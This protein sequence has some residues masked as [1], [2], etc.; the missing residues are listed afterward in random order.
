MFDWITHVL[1]Q[2]G[3]I[4][5]ALL[6][7]AENVFPPIPSELIMPLAGFDASRGSMSLAW[8][9]LS[10]SVGS[11]AGAVFWYYVGRWLGCERIKRLAARHGRWITVSPEEIDRSAD[12]FRRHSG[13][14]VF[15]GRLVPAIRTLISIPAGV[16]EMSL[17]RFLLYS[18]LGTVL[19]TGFLAVSGYLLQAQYEKVSSYV[20]P[21]ADIVVAIIVIS[22]IYR[23]ATFRR[24]VSD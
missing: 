3:Y 5:I 20:N 24:N 16:A 17:G 11:L 1:D 2:T 9:I 14:A 8:V 7:L 19:W 13:K 6:M 10:G 12:W 15:I 21:V 18:T 4:G 23:V 22:Y